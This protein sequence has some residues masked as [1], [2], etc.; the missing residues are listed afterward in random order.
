M[1]DLH[2]GKKLPYWFQCIP[3]ILTA[4]ETIPET[5]RNSPIISQVHSLR[6][7]NELQIAR[8]LQ[9][10]RLRLLIATSQD[11]NCY[12][13]ATKCSFRYK[14]HGKTQIYPSLSA[15][16]SER[17]YMRFDRLR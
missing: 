5:I 17:R 6:A 2:E 12:G 1:V 15:N 7:R 8:T 10:L 11:F 14:E 9:R 16:I 4:K 13:N 3:S